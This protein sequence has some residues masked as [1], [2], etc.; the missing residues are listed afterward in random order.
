MFFTG[1]I[2]PRTPT[3]LPSSNAFARSFIKGSSVSIPSSDHVP[4]LRKAHGPSP[5]GTAATAEAV[6]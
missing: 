2:V 3:S 6:S 4:E 5:A 1:R